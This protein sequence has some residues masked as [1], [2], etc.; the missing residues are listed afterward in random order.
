MQT[1]QPIRIVEYQDH[2]GRTARIGITKQGRL[3][4]VVANY[5]E[6]VAEG[7]CF[8][9]ASEAKAWCKFNDACAKLPNTFKITRSA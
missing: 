2:L 6:E 4:R 9:T 1:L 3:F 7:L 5:P 8:V